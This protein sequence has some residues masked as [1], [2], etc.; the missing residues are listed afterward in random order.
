MKIKEEW[1]EMKILPYAHKVKAK[2]RKCITNKKP[3]LDIMSQCRIIS[4]RFETKQTIN[5]PLKNAKLQFVLSIHKNWAEQQLYTNEF[6]IIE[7][8]M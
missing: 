2:V 1:E 5:K 6:L 3:T 7:K 4:F 8:S